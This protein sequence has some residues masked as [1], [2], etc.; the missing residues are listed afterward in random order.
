MNK[1][2][3]N[4]G[5][6]L[7]AETVV[8]AIQKKKG[9]NIV[10]LNLEKIPNAVC[11]RFIICDGT[12]RTQVTAIAESIDSGVKTLLGIDPWHREGYENAE[13]ILLDYVDV[14]VHIFQEK[15]RSFYQLE[16]LWADAKM[17]KYRT[18]N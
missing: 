8:E 10:G 17:K 13:W 4:T 18:D 6:G 14:V 1:G 5:T 11:K 12:S 7:L 16:E 2:T 15:T 9:R 3:I